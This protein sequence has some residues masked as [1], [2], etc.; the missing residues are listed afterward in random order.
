MSL[1]KFD[2]TN[3]KLY[4]IH[5]PKTSGT[6]FTSD[7]IIKLG[8]IFNASNIYR[9]PKNKKGYCD[10][11]TDTWSTYYYEYPQYYKITIIRNPFD[12]LCSY[13]HHGEI[14]QNNNI[15][16]HSGWAAV[17]YTHN[18]T[19]FK[20]FITAYCDDNFE[21]HIPA[22]KKFLFSQ[23]FDDNHNCVTDIIVK[24]EFCDEAKNLLNLKLQ[25]KISTEKANIS[26]NKKKHYKE[27]YDDEMI[28]NVN[29]KCE[30]E[31]KYY[32]YDFN[33]STKKEIFIIDSNIKYDIKND[34]VY[35]T[36]NS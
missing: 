1:D 31:L 33:G 17:N 8:H 12:L 21:W 25:S 5:I 22:L 34:I 6:A 14:F 30:R 18:F 10:Y 29:K 4:F 11:I 2:F 24:Y 9:T 32:N 23:L 20:E 27:Y 26:I 19:T 36:V 28:Q 15:F 13:Y 7:Q 3:N 16:C 35:L